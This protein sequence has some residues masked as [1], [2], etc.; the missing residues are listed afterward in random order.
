MGKE[1]DQLFIVS[2]YVQGMT[3][4]D[5][6]TGK[7]PTPKEAAELCA[8]IADA[9]QHAHEHGVIHRDLKPSNI[10]LDEDGQPHIMDFGL[11]K[12]EAGEITMTMEGRVLGTPAYMSPEQAKGAAHDADQRSDVY[13]LGVILFEL[14]TGELPFRGNARMLI[15]QVIND[16]PPGPR[17]LNNQVP[18]DLDTICLK[19]LEKDP[20]KRYQTAGEL[21]QDL[22]RFLDGEPIEARPV[23]RV[24]RGWRWCKRNPTVAS[25]SVL[26]LALLFV[27]T[28]VSSYFALEA[29]TRAK[30][31]LEAKKTAD[32]E[33][34]KRRRF[35]YISDM[36]V[37]RQAW[38][39]NDVGR[40]IA[41]LKDHWPSSGEDDLRGFE[42]YY[43]WQVCRRSQEVRH[44]NLPDGATDIAFSPDGRLLAACSADHPVQVYDYTSD[45]VRI[46][47]KAREDREFLESY[48]AFSPDGTTIAYPGQ[49]GES[50]A[51]WNLSSSERR[52]LHGP[53]QKT[54]CVAFSTSGSLLAAGHADGTI[55]IWNLDSETRPT[56][57]PA[58][59]RLPG[60][61]GSVHCVA[62]LRDGKTLVSG[63][64]DQTVRFWDIKSQSCRTPP[65][66]TRKSCV[67]SQS[68]PTVVW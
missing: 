18:V 55:T 35:L 30:V 25:L 22:Q 26:V 68:R 47:L 24:E 2:D 40:V 50:V 62:F 59:E 37:A 12:R 10:M 39:D 15:H 3:L 32:A 67:R 21:G 14:L 27:G 20:D 1:D 54:F 9:V 64:L 5:W 63:G 61:E 36:N 11:A 19:C 4:A 6:L 7:R 23:S 42:W 38:N 46:S 44:L 43:L 29:N 51:L 53:S 13:S 31:A 34:E 57:L 48:V 16:E 41:L 66:N 56:I 8:K 52:A 49:D 45:Q 17:K 33:S 60:H 58:H 28:A 65:K